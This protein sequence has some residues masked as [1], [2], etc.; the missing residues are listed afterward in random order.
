[1]LSF[2]ALIVPNYDGTFKNIHLA[3]YVEVSRTNR[4]R[5]QPTACVTD[6]QSV[7]SAGKGPALAP[8]AMVP[9]KKSTARSGTFSLTL[10]A[11]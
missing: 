5:G 1:V 9:A 10:K 6:G 11:F 2:G 8:T 3:L 4:A 7:K